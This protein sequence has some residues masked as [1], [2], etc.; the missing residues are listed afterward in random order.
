[1]PYRFLEHTADALF[2]AEN[3]SF[4]LALEDAAAAMSKVMSNEIRKVEE[5]EFTE[6]AENLEELVVFTLSTL[7]A[8]SQAR[9]LIPGGMQITSFKRRGKKYWIRAIGWA[10]KGETKNDIK[11]VT[12]HLLKVEIGKDFCKIR[13]LVD[14]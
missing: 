2:E 11:A 3:V 7:L 10:G 5:F 13:V 8:E 4:E 9:G 6:S 14:I 1:M 12:H